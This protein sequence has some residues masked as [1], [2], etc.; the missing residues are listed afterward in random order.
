M[1]SKSTHSNGS[2]STLENPLCRYCGN[3]LEGIGASCA[4][5]DYVKELKKR[6]ADRLALYSTPMTVKPKPHVDTGLALLREQAAKERADAASEQAYADR[7]RAVELRELE[8]R[9]KRLDRF[10]SDGEGQGES[11][12]DAIAATTLDDLVAKFEGAINL[13]PTPSV[14]DRRNGDG[15]MVLPAGKISWL[16][17]LPGSGKSFHKRDSRP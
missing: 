3:G 13:G 5:P 17:G 10:D 15:G 9:E 16:Y 12:Q 7:V 2:K 4:C 11:T 14:L 1:S 8:R 6:E